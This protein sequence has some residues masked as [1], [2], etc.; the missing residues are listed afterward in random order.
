MKGRIFGQ[1][2]FLKVILTS[3]HPATVVIFAWISQGNVQH[4]IVRSAVTSSTYSLI[5]RFVLINL[6]LIYSP[7][8]LY[9]PVG[10]SQTIHKAHVYKI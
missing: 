3:P 1:K 6:S 7:L 10:L 5:V 9:C 4:S 2:I 8:T